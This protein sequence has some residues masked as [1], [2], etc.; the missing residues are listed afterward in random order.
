MS[1][2]QFDTPILP[3]RPCLVRRVSA[4]GA[5][6]HEDLLATEVPVAL[7]FNGLSHVV[8]MCSPL[9]LDDFA[10]GFSLSEGIVERREEIFSIETVERAAG[11]ELHLELASAR[12]SALKERRRQLTGR[13]GCG[14]C[15]VESL[16][17]A[18][19]PVGHVGQTLQLSP[20]ALG[21]ALAELENGQA[22]A[23]ETGCTHAAAWCAPDGKVVAVREDVGRHVAFDKLIGARAQ[24]DWGAGFALL[25]SR[26]SYELVHKAAAVGIELLAAMSAPTALAVELA[27]TSG[28][29]LAAFVRKQRYGIYSHPER[30]P[31][32]VPH[33]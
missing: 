25:S 18:I 12:F 20:G 33:H 11:I 32:S 21:H 13:T 16:Q 24:A 29:T 17:Q 23:M 3:T 22:L 30:V 1:D 5:R 2:V 4:D 27:Q 7:V 9:D 19:R 6:D 10:L 26:A 15:G 14:L 8:M 31:D 28:L